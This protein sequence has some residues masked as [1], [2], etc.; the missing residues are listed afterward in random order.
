[1][2]QLK[3]VWA[4]CTKQFHAEILDVAGFCGNVVALA[5]SV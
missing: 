3:R 1:M 2:L 4:L 5:Y